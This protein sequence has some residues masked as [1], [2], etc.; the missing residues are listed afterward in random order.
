MVDGVNGVEG[1][2]SLNW[3]YSDK[4]V[5]PF[6]QSTNT[7][8]QSGGFI[9]RATVTNALFPFYQWRLN[10][11]NILS[12]TND[13]LV[14]TDLQVTMAGAY[15]VV[16]SNFAGRTTNTIAMVTVDVPLLHPHPT[17]IDGRLRIRLP[18]SDAPQLIVETSTDLLQWLPL[19]TVGPSN[20][21]P[22]QDVP[23]TNGL[24]F[25]RARP[26]PEEQ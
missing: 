17:V 12:A 8:R 11:Q 21:I 23:A 5:V 24:H 25:F 2:I 19:F 14:L 3:N 1:L 20:T 18:G 22:Y 4:P 10:G 26:W 9:L 13:T 7:I 6:P 16:V 15:S